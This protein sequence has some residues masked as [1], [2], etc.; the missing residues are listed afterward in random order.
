MSSEAKLLEPIDCELIIGVLGALGNQFQEVIRRLVEIWFGHPNR[1]PTF[2]EYAIYMAHSAALRSADLSRQ[3][4]A[5]LTRGKQILSTGAN[6]CPE[7]HGGLYWT[8]QTFDPLCNNDAEAGRDY[9]RGID[10]NRQAQLEM[11]D[12]RGTEVFR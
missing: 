2:D 8:S 4:G 12:A 11:I 9:R 5:V 3:V 6:E 7:A 1:T 10:S